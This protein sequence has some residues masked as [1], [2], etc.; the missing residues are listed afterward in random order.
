MLRAAL[1]CL[2]GKFCGYQVALRPVGAAI[3]EKP[4]TR[5]KA[6]IPTR[7]L[8]SLGA[9]AQT[10]CGWRSEKV[11]HTMTVGEL[12]RLAQLLFKQVHRKEHRDDRGAVAR[13][14]LLGTY[15][16]AGALGSGDADVGRR[17]ATLWGRCLGA[18]P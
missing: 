7:D 14:A 13:P 11:P 1:R 15:L 17:R 10:S 3:V 5:K 4:V 12:K 9:A 8:R 18:V 2:A 6:F 16:V